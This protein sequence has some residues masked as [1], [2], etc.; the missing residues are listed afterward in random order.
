ML[1]RALVYAVAEGGL[2]YAPKVTLPKEPNPKDCWLTR[3]EAARLLRASAPHLRRFILISLATGRRASTVLALRWT[4]SLT[5]GWVD[6]ERGIIHFRGQAEQETAK[7]KGA[8]LMPRQLT[9]HARR[10]ARA[11]GSHVIMWR[12]AG[13]HSWEMR[14]IAE[15]DTAL[16]AAARRAGLDGVTPHVLK[17]T[18]VTWH[19]SAGWLARTRRTG[20]TRPPARSSGSTGRSL[21]TTR[22]G[23]ARSWKGEVDWRRDSGD[24]KRGCLDHSRRRASGYDPGNVR[25][26][27]FFVNAAMADGE[28]VFREIGGGRRSRKRDPASRQE[29]KTNRGGK[30]GRKMRCNRLSLERAKGFEPSTPTLARL[31]STPELHPRPTALYIG[32]LGW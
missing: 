20:S 2:I 29:G 18:A 32:G 4:P 7:R 24:G 21:R 12:A 5:S 11:G 3:N 16:A 27:L 31:C 19:S 14:P 15:I 30:G 10:W 6:L 17:H 25:L 23:R 13:K 8:V 26:V 9:A 1:Q 22:S 28:A